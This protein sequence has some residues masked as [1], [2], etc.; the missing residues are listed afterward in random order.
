MGRYCQSSLIVDY[1]YDFGDS[2]VCKTSLGLTEMITNAAFPEDSEQ[3]R[4]IHRRIKDAQDMDP[5]TV[6]PYGNLNTRENRQ[7]TIPIRLL[8]LDTAQGIF[9]LVDKLTGVVIGDDNSIQFALHGRMKPIFG[10]KFLLCTISLAKI[11]F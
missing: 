8:L 6:P 9:Q 2:L 3:T 1:L 10:G 11:I 7:G 4:R 5:G